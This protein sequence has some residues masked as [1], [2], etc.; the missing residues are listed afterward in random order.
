M[1]PEDTGRGT[2]GARTRGKSWRQGMAA[3]AAATASLGCLAA[4]P[5]A[6]SRDVATAAAASAPAVDHIALPDD[7][8]PSAYRLDITPDAPHRR[9]TGRLAVDVDVLRATRRVVL[10]AAEIVVTD[11]R[12]DRGP[13]ATVRYDQRDETVALQF[14]RPLAP[15]HHVLRID[16]RGGIRSQA[17]GLFTLQEPAG[18]AAPGAPAASAAADAATRSGAAARAASAGALEAWPLMFT[19]FENSDARRFLP[20]WDEPA[21]KA[22]FELSATIPGGLVPVGNMPV[23]E[24]R[25][26]PDGRRH[27]RFARTPRMSSYLLFFALGY[28][29]RIHRV[30]DGVDVGVVVRR[31]HAE[32]GRYA[33][34]SAAQLLTYFNEWFGIAYPLPKLDLVAGPGSNLGF[35]AMENWGAIFFF[36][37][38]LLLDPAVSTEADRRDVFTTV[39]H[40]IA[41]QWFGN[42]V[43]MAWWDDLWLNEGFATWMQTKAADHLHPDWHLATGVLSRRGHTMAVDQRAGTHPVIMPIRDVLQADS[44]FD[45][46][47]YGKGSAVVRELEAHVGA[48]AF[49]AGVRRYLAAHAYGNTTS[50]DFFAA[51]DEA[52]GQ[53]VST[54]A[55]DLTR[56]AGVP[57]VVEQSATCRDGATDVVLSQSRFRD[58]VALGAPDAAGG[59]WHLPVTLVVA[60]AA[61]PGAGSAPPAAATAASGAGTPAR[62]VVHGPA[63]QHVG[64]PGCGA[65]VINAGQA[66]YF[67]TRYTPQGLAALAAAFPALAPVDQL[68]LLD[69]AG[70]LALAG[71][72]PM[73]AWL[74]LL[75]RV[76]A[77]A[78]PVVLGAMVAQLSHLDHLSR[79]LPVQAPLRAFARDRL[80]PLLARVGD[81]ARAGELDDV[82]TLRS[83]L[84]LALAEFGDAG[85]LASARERFERLRRDPSA[86]DVNA[87]HEVLA[88]VA[89]DA[90][91]DEWDALHAMARAAHAHVERLELYELLGSARRPELAE[92]ALQL[93][94]SGEPPETLVAPMFRDVSQR[95]PR[96]AFDVVVAHWPALAG[97]F[98]TAGESLIVPHLLDRADSAADVA[99]LEAFA[100]AWVRPTGR[101]EVDKVEA[102][103]R[104]AEAVRSQRLPQLAAWLGTR[105]G[106]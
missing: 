29:E 61:A 76:P 49:R 30:V 13:A 37:Q 28:F 54:I 1:K 97:R 39:A 5:A 56:Q 74:D 52:A 36:E 64:V 50:D 98:D 90:T 59:L 3:L 68:G 26:L 53:R 102:G 95:H 94:L 22:T 105:A 34:D 83:D 79:G 106:S 66:G 45:A 18:P 43:T 65:L 35:G 101:L 24:D 42:L 86:L 104:V 67:R 73:G 12:M 60:G 16:Y 32:E 89:M 72:L 70:A 96:R 91:P 33:L 84:L 41:H 63:P 58:D 10:N 57:M 93:A 9:F 11:A 25:R 31:G 21:R 80:R 55:H 8:I 103:I 69:D 47:T 81:A 75:Q 46:I 85:V 78:D 51:L 99:A 19:Q 88:I 15:G 27:V 40:E 77:D 62:T 44:A 82:T 14:P 4:A 38:A 6:P 23:A 92:R 7:V 71:A 17:T 2:G 20:C 87:R 100:K 48:D